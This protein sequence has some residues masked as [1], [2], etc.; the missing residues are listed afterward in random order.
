MPKRMPKRICNDNDNDNDNDYD[1]NNGNVDDVDDVN[2]VKF[3]PLTEC[4]NPY[5]GNWRMPLSQ[6]DQKDQC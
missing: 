5:Q 1:N 4:R 2:G 6:H 3:L